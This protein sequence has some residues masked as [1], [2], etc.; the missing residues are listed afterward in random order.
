MTGLE[1][2]RSTLVWLLVD[3]LSNPLARGFAARH[4]D[5]F[6]AR[7]I[8]GDE[9][10]QARA[11]RPLAP[12]CQ[13]PPS[14]FTI[15]SG[16]TPEEHGLL[17]YD[18]PAPTADEPL[19]H[20]D[21]F[22]CW[23]REPRLVWDRLAAAGRTIRMSAV[24]FVQ[25]AR[26]GDALISWL[27]PYGRE[28]VAP[29]ILAPGD[30]WDDIGTG[31]V[32]EVQAGGGGV[33][34][35]DCRATGRVVLTIAP[36]SAQALA[37]PGGGEP[38]AVLLMCLSIEDQL[39]LV[40]LA[41]HETLSAGRAPAP[42][43]RLR[44]LGGDAARFY[45]ERRLGPRLCE[46]GRGE[47]ERHLV[48]LMRLAHRSFADD[49]VEAVRAGDADA[50]IGYYPVIDLL[51]HHLLRFV[52]PEV[53]TAAER[54]VCEPLLDAALRDVDILLADCAAGPRAVTL[55]AH[56]DHGMLPVTHDVY[57]NRALSTLDLLHF[58]ASGIDLA[59]SA[60]FFHPCEN[61][62][63]VFH[64]GRLAERGLALSGVVAAVRAQLPPVLQPGWALVPGPAAPTP[65]PWIASQYLQA[66]PSARWR[67]AR[68]DALVAASSKGGEHNVACDDPWLRGV[69]FEAGPEAHSL[70]TGQNEL[71][72]LFDRVLRRPALAPGVPAAA[73]NRA[74]HRPPILSPTR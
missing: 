38:D 50:V 18:T 71:S 31:A 44:C 35:R 37:W 63:L 29:T 21:A 9:C 30:T 69:L 68:G 72:S 55:L 23:P 59:R 39:R 74:A 43:T 3:G 46:G 28:L 14:L 41:R 27:S 15:W 65:E 26:L 24:P 51:C 25:P 66:P 1:D 60:V 45:Q 73:P 19:R 61:G 10:H 49:V 67:A 70:P 5:S 32:F 58:D 36:G 53:A 6:I 47:A 22:A 7:C 64:P 52:H 2:Q 11:L 48:S 4:P 57:V 20:A 13:T 54:A 34:L 33:Q 16:L 62:L 17:G 42:A 8:E 12:N 40:V 56:S